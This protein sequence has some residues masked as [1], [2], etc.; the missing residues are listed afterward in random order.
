MIDWQAISR[1][2]GS[3][4]W[5]TG[6]RLLG[7]DADAADCFQETFLCALDVSKRQAVRNWPAL[8]QRLATARA[9]D[10]LRRRK[11][12][13]RSRVEAAEWEQVASEELGPDRRVEDAEF[14][15]SLRAAVAKLPGQ[16]GEVFCL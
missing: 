13:T 10:L 16:Q 6:Y 4:V 8:L 5:R 9:L 15:E 7:S 1:Q 14:M 3:L 12:E 2:Y 11:R